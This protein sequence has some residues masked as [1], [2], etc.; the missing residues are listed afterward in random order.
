MGFILSC[1]TTPKRLNKLIQIIPHLK[2]N[3]K[4]FV[5]NVCSEYKRFGKFKIP[6]KLLQLCKSNKIDNLLQ[7]ILLLVESILL[8][9]VDQ[10]G[11]IQ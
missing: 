7:V 6:K 3:Y 5:I 10:L 4:F 1:T 9:Q 2:V 8:D 11:S